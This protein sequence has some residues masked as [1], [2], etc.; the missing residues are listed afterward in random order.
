VKLFFDTSA[1]VKRYFN[2]PGSDDVLSLCARAD[3]VAVSAVLPVEIISTLA[4]LKRERRLDTISFNQ[5]KKA[6]FSDLA[7]M[8]VI[9]LSPQVISHAVAAVEAM[10]LK[11]L[12]A[13][14]IG[15][16]LEYKPDLFV[17]GD[18]QQISSAKSAGLQVKQLSME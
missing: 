6:F 13:L 7:D 11:S 3:D 8:T 17:S 2:E 4:R 15:C 5:I 18:K 14:H 16:A 10:P 12:D 9:L 1:L